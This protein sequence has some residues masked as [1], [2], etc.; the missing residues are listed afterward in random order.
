MWAFLSKLIITWYSHMDVFLGNI[1]TLEYGKWVIQS[2]AN[3]PRFLYYK[4]SLKETDSG[5]FVNFKGVWD[6]VSR[7]Y[8]PENTLCKWLAHLPGKQNIPGLNPGGAARHFPTWLPKHIFGSV[9]ARRVVS[10]P[11]KIY[12]TRRVGFLQSNV[13]QLGS[14]IRK[15][16]SIR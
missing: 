8:T 5:S 13:R 6:H 4:S 7:F 16:R 10:N 9:K 11:F 2:L 12:E 3:L 14:L 1:T 15:L